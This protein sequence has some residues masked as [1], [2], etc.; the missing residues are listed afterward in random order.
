MN[1]IDGSDEINIRF[2]QSARFFVCGMIGRFWYEE[3]IIN[4]VIIFN[5][6]F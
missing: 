2:H 6:D 1:Q 3:G 4:G 5:W